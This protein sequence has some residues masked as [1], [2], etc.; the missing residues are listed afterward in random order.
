M[1]FTLDSVSEVLFVGVTIVEMREKIFDLPMWTKT[2]GR[3]GRQAQ[4][5]PI[6]G[7]S[8]VIKP[9]IAACFV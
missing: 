1:P 7:S 8:A 4:V 6:I 2:N 3:K 5:T 9:T